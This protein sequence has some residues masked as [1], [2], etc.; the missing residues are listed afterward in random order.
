MVVQ[1]RMKLLTS[2]NDGK[3]DSGE[4]LQVPNAEINSKGFRALYKSR[5]AR[6][7]SEGA[8]LSDLFW[9][10]LSPGPEIHPEQVEDGYKYD[11]LNLISQRVLTVERNVLDGMLSKYAQRRIDSVSG[12]Q[13]VRLRDWYMELFAGFLHEMIFG[14]E[15]C[16]E[17][18]SMIVAH[19]QNVIQTLHWVTLRNMDT[20]LK[21]VDYCLRRIR[22]G[23]LS[24]RILDGVDRDAIS[25]EDIAVLLANAFFNTGVVQSSEAMTHASL[26][27]A[28]TP[29]A[30]KRLSVP[31]V[32]P[33]YCQGFVN[34][35][36][37][38]WPLFGIT[39]RILT[40]DIKLPSDCGSK[41]G[42]VVKKGTVVCYNFPEY[43]SR[44]YEQ[45]KELLP[46]RWFTLKPSQ[47]NFCPFGFASNRPC[48][49]QSLVTK[50]MLH[51]VPFF[52]ARVDF[53]SPVEH[54]RSLAGA[55]LCVVSPK[56][57]RAETTSLQRKALQTAIWGLEE[58]RKVGR[59]LIQ[60]YCA[61]VIVNDAKQLRLCKRFFDSGCKPLPLDQ[62][63]STDTFSDLSTTASEGSTTDSD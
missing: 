23:A 42:T 29:E 27:L 10:F 41:S 55:G 49:A 37:R 36:F 24:A 7:R 34:E 21:V 1:H 9:Y 43:H 2:I 28:H 6:G 18:T 54:M 52:A 39:H 56:Q 32:S 38:L 40:G 4:G 30:E 5:A 33:E 13:V 26:A 12:L 16:E 53:E 8:G 17:V 57:S 11:Q 58:I 31:V 60:F 45:A 48:P 19:A 22:E 20:R 62:K 51:L 47:V 3:D 35:C 14:D 59:S 25:D 63:F 15:P 61:S 50:Y 46:E 44:G